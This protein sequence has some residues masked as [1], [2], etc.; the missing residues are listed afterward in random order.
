MPAWGRVAG[1]GR[2]CAPRTV[3]SVRVPPATLGSWG[4][5]VWWLG[6]GCYRRVVLAQRAAES[7]HGA[8]A[9]HAQPGSG[10]RAIVTMHRFALMFLRMVEALVDCPNWWLCLLAYESVPSWARRS[11]CFC[12]EGLVEP[13]LGDGSPPV[14]ERVGDP[15]LVS[16]WPLGRAKPSG[17]SPRLALTI[18]HEPN[19]LRSGSMWGH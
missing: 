16:F 12:R 15:T 19:Y 11:R 3:G 10:P 2:R 4:C 8:Q 13:A 17:C 7:W 18:M 5:A 1:I 9:A 14:A 6:R